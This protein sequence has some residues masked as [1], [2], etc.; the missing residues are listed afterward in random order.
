M[1]HWCCATHPQVYGATLLG[2]TPPHT[3]DAH[4]GLPRGLLYDT[5]FSD[6]ELLVFATELGDLEGGVG[7]GDALDGTVESVVN[8][9][10]VARHNMLSN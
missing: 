9:K 3:A 8:H 2:G 10:V 7:E 1:K 4:K 6:D 5:P